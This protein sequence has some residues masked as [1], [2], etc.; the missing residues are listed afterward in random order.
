MTQASSKAQA[1]EK[2]EI[3]RLR[4]QATID[5]AEIRRLQKLNEQLIERVDLAE[6]VAE[7]Q[8]AASARSAMMRIE[9]AQAEFDAT[10][11]ESHARRKEASEVIERLRESLKGEKDRVKALELSQ[12]DALKKI[13]LSQ[14]ELEKNRREFEKLREARDNFKISASE[15]TR[16]LAT[17]QKMILSKEQAIQDKNEFV[18]KLKKE[19]LEAKQLSDE[20]SEKIKQLI[21][22]KKEAD[23]KIKELLSTKK[24]RDSKISEL[25]ALKKKNSTEVK[26]LKIELEQRFLE[27]AQLQKEVLRRSPGYQ[28]KKMLGAK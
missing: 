4:R 26:R 25:I 9:Q 1:D 2:A 19:R 20:R 27:I 10:L 28:L 12:R 11:A 7:T 22:A 5:Q 13:E 17:L 16:E 3:Q 8:A 15:R 24:E 14:K 23:L 21:A 18:E 6:R